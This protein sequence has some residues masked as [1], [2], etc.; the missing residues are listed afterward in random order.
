MWIVILSFLSLLSMQQNASSF[1]NFFKSQSIPV[2]DMRFQDESVI[3]KLHYKDVIDSADDNMK[4]HVLTIVRKVA[5]EFKRSKNI[6]IEIFDTGELISE[7][8]FSALNAF[9]YAQG[10]IGDEEILSKITLKEHITIEDMM[11]SLTHEEAESE[12]PIKIINPPVLDSTKPNVAP[13]YA[14]VLEGNNRN[15]NMGPKILFMDDF[16][17]ENNGHGNLNYRSWQP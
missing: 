15:K 14:K 7:L 13:N 17:S 11:A 9:A 2:E 5:E 12:K 8:S 3:L 4:H 10:N 16:N 6:I 1:L